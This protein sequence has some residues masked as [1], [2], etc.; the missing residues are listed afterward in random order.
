MAGITATGFERKR[1]ADIKVD[2]ENELKTT[3]GNGINLDP[4]SVFGQIVGIFAEREDLVWQGLEDVYN[5]QYPDTAFGV[6]LDNVAALTG[7]QRIPARPAVANVTLTGSVGT[8][9]PLGSLVAVPNNGPQF[10]TLTQ[11][12]IPSGSSISVSV[13]S[14]NTGLITAAAGT[15]TAIV[16]PITGW[17]AVTNPLDATP[18]N[19]VES[20]TALRIRR[21]QQLQ[22]SGAATVEAM[23]ASLLTVS[24]VTQ[25][26]IFENTSMVT[27]LNGLPP[28]SFQAFVQGG[29]NQAIGNKI[30]AVKAAGILSYGTITT[31]VVDSQ[32]ITHLINWSRPVEKNIYVIVNLTTNPSK[33]PV[34]GATLTR[35]AILAYGSALEIGDP[36]IVIPEMIASIASIS[37]ILNA[38]ILVGLSPNP[39]GSANIIQ[40]V[41][42]IAKFDSTRITV[43]VT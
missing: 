19:E 42:E 20:D 1:L 3:F 43:N 40:N 31:S 30:W 17:N 24:G 14:V 26:I 7:I 11:T 35:D 39:T 21:E 6:S 16:T 28:K 18:G 13:E 5:S 32:G 22:K 15:I 25:V 9:I 37:G 23:R 27:D 33:F 10:K 38:T 4:E 34:N 36:V 41:N 2:I 29:A 8:I 12:V